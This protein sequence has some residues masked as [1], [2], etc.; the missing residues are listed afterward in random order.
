[1]GNGG[2]TRKHVWEVFQELAAKTELC[3][4]E[5]KHSWISDDPSYLVDLANLGFL[6]QALQ[7]RT[8]FEIGTSTGYSSLFIAAN[9]GPDTRIWTLDLPAGDSATDSSLT[10]HDQR[11][12]NGCHEVEPCFAG[13]RLGSKIRRVYGDSVRFDFSPYRRSVDL[14]FIDGAHTY[15]YVRTDTINALFCCHRGSVIAWHDYG[16]TGLSRDVSKWLEQLNRIVPV[17]AGH[18]S[19]LAFMPCNFDCEELAKT[20]DAGHT[21]WE[22]ADQSDHQE[23][24]SEAVSRS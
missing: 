6:C 2:L 23:L 7:P 4:P 20:L 8:V 5:L 10:V 19:S 24:A 17:Y 11:I 12:V 22:R 21:G 1:M 15:E 3:F 16:R 13:H 14:F 18:G 9:T